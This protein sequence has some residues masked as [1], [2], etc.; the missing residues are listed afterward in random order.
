MTVVVN[1]LSL[2]TDK[3]PDENNSSFPLLWL[4]VAVTS[5][6]V[7]ILVATLVLYCSRKNQ[8]KGMS[9][10]S[11]MLYQISKRQCFILKLVPSE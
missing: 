8:N 7:M 2:L 3:S 6:S 11:Q 10:L 5:A 4:M 1:V 9:V